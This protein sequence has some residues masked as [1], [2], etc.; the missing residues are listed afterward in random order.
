MNE[1]EL[2]RRQQEFDAK[3][4]NEERIEPKDWMPPRLS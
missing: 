4:A 2:E 3:V 1:K